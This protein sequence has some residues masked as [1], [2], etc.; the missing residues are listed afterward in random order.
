MKRSIDNGVVLGCSNIYGY[1]K[2]KGKLVIDE[3]QAK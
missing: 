3:E 2:D 1:V